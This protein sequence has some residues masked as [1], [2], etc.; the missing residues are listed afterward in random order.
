VMCKD[1]LIQ[2]NLTYIHSRMEAVQF[3]RNIT[4][5]SMLLSAI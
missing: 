5:V 2:Q 1:G 4:E 3:N